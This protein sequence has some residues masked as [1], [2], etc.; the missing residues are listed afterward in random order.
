MQ[1]FGTGGKVL[2]GSTDFTI[3]FHYDLPPRVTQATDFATTDP[4]LAEYVRVQAVE[5]Q[6]PL[7]FANAFAALT[8]NPRPNNDA[9]AFAVAGLSS[10]TC[11]AVQIWFC[12]PSTTPT[13][14]VDDALAARGVDVGD[15]I[16]LIA[17]GSQGRYGAGNWGFID[18]SSIAINPSGPCGGINGTGPLLRCILGATERIGQCIEGRLINVE[19]GQK[20]GITGVSI[21]TRFDIYEGSMQSER[22]NPDYAPA[23]IVTKGI[24]AG[25]GNGNGGGNSC[26]GQNTALTT[27]TSA[28]LRDDCFYDSPI[29]CQDDRFGDGIWDFEAYMHANYDTD[30]DDTNTTA[31]KI[32]EY[33][34]W[35]EDLLDD[36]SGPMD[37]PISRWDVYQEEVDDIANF[38]GNPQT[39]LPNTPSGPRDEDSLPSCYNGSTPLAPSIGAK[40]RLMLAAAVDCNTQTISG[41]QTG[42]RTAGYI[43]FFLTETVGKNPVV[44]GNEVNL[45]GEVTEVYEE[46]D[47]DFITIFQEVP[48]LAD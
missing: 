28:L 19:P 26:I 23:P 32:V 18:Q 14:G 33:P 38:P 35:Y 22:N 16:H 39:T 2:S 11:D 34:D 7:T 47:F 42:V 30:G 27:N 41:S 17:G 31:E 25:N 15:M 44:V 1:T 48:Y 37:P 45:F 20:K 12:L 36:H 10:Y 9:N 13:P 6:V 3:T 43:E 5:K 21:N 40:R 8:G 46:G 4:A 29:S 24:I